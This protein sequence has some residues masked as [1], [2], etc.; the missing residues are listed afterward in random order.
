MATTQTMRR[1]KNRDTWR[2]RAVC[3]AQEAKLEQ[4]PREG[5]GTQSQNPWDRTKPTT[6]H[7]CTRAADLAPR[8]AMASA[9]KEA[10]EKT[11]SELPPVQSTYHTDTARR[12]VA[13]EPEAGVFRE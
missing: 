3:V 2:D 6:V 8:S 10:F 4:N 13:L 5:T 7:I 12:R 1:L 11:I 9:R